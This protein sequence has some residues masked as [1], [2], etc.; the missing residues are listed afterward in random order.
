MA[1]KKTIKENYSTTSAV[2]V[3]GLSAYIAGILYP[4]LLPLAL[5][6]AVLTKK[7]VRRELEIELDSVASDNAERIASI[8]EANRGLGEKG[9]TISFTEK[10]ETPLIMWPITRNYHFHPEG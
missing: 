4:P 6:G 7:M 3:G 5:I 1:M 2:I 8:W 9:I 10:K